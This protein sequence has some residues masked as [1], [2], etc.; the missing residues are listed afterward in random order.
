MLLL[1][2]MLIIDR[3]VQNCIDHRTFGEQAACHRFPYQEKEGGM[4]LTGP[5]ET[6]TLPPKK[7]TAPRRT[8]VPE[9]RAVKG[10][11]PKGTAG[12]AEDR[13][14]T[15]S[16]KALREA[17]ILLVEEQGLN[18]LTVN[19]LCAQ[20]DLNR[21][22]FYNHF[23]DIPT[24]VADLKDEFM[25]GLEDYQAQMRGLT[26]ADLAAYRMGK[27][28][29][30]F[31]VGLFDYLRSEGDLLHA[32]LGP[33]GDIQFGPWLQ[34]SICKNLVHTILHER[35]RTNPEPFVNYYVAYFASAYLG[36]IMRWI[37]TGMQ[38][39]SEEMALIAMRL[40]FIKPGEPIT[41]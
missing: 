34:D 14:I 30:P 27:R 10:R 17:L 8:P 16:K 11:R 32:L 36:V 26:L 9:A 24:L 15:R 4:P 40:F 25:A 37:E 1:D 29:L 18:N 5:Q 35:Y 22:T 7:A 38:E 3:N 2:K 28:P 41:L 23:Q 39:S 12:G 33:G 31:L 6:A 20:A 21:G 13:R 19:D